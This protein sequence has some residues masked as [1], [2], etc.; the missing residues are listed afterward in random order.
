VIGQPRV[1]QVIWLDGE[2]VPWHQATMHVAAHHYG[3]GVFEGVRAYA[4]QAGTQ[5]FRLADHTRRLFRSARMLKLALP[6]AFSAEL[7]N[8]AQLELVRRNRF[9]D[10]YLR[11][12]VFLDGVLGL[13][14]CMRDL[15]VHV[16][17]LG[18][19]WK[20]SA[21][22]S[23]SSARAARGVT[24][25][26]SSFVRHPASSSLAKA[27]ANGN[28]VTGMLALEE[29]QAAGADDAMLLDQN[30]HV[31]ETTGANL[32]VVKDGEL[33][34]APLAY[35]LDGI[36]RDTVQVL[37]AEKGWQ[38]RER[39]LTRDEVYVA[40]EVFL[41]GTANEIMPVLRVDG[42]PI[43]TGDIGPI[44]RALQVAYAACVRGQA[45]DQ[46]GWLSKVSGSQVREV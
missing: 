17:I 16:A 18:V 37:A 38:T 36:T 46:R 8:D 12:F 22:P 40:D 30:G 42:R 21:D 1:D 33:H 25:N 6:P 31:T 35:V 27:K 14:P 41:T 26:T 10:A 13:R 11:P 4:S 39:A 15:N 34:T 43:G 44:T 32:F 23:R 3:F 28:Y 5:V 19:D 45:P 2:F 29:A 9:G 7:L 24:L 20:E